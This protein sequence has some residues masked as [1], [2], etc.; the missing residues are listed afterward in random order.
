MVFGMTTFTLVHV[1]L[2]LIGILSG[3]MVL[4]GL[5]TSNLM[6]GWTTVFLAA[7]LATSVTGFF[8]PFH[9][10]TPGIV[11]G[12]LSII[13][14][15]GAAAGRYGFHLAGAWRGIY[16]AGSVAALYFNVFVLVAQAFDKIP[17]LHALAPTKPPSGPA[18]A[19][20]QGIVLVFFVVVGVLAV[21]RFRPATA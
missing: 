4:Y 2:S 20:S 14:L 1:L 13:A 6:N 12:V 10:V 11:L 18:F 7:T 15:A 21:R 5:V 8:F 9:G 17:A 19:I 16:V 3:F